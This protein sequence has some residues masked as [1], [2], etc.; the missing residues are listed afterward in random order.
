MKEQKRH[1]QEKNTGFIVWDSVINYINGYKISVKLENYKSLC[2]AMSW[3]NNPMPIRP[4]NTGSTGKSRQDHISHWN[5]RPTIWK[6][7]QRCSRGHYQS[8]DICENPI[9]WCFDF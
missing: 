5:K 4:C 9:L 7:E 2:Y 1:Y 8:G 3:S 6:R